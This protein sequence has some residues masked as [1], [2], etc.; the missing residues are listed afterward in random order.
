MQLSLKN[1]LQKVS[2]SL[3]TDNLYV[4][5]TELLVQKKH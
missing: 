3:K 1:I 4:N 2:L 5:M